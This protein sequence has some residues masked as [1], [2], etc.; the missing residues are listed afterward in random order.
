MSHL[1]SSINLI[2]PLITAFWD[3]RKDHAK[4]LESFPKVTSDNEKKYPLRIYICNYP[5]AGMAAA[6]ICFTSVTDWF[7]P[8][9]TG[10][11]KHS[12]F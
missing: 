10:Y 5:L 11:R 3:S 9:I 8:F 12:C 2:K 6:S 4:L 1:V 7:S